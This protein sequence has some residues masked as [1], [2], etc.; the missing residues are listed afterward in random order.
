M[1]SV[2]QLV[3]APDCGFGGHRFETGL[4]PKHMWDAAVVAGKPHKLEVGGSNPPPATSNE[5][6]PEWFKGQ[7]FK[8]C[9]RR[10]ESVL[11]LK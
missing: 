11:T 1:V 5:W 2:A 9:I 3:R 10:F 6:V 8:T 7:V 4:S